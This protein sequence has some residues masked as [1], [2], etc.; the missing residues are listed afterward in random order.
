MVAATEQLEPIWADHLDGYSGAVERS[1]GEQ[2]WLK[3][4]TADFP[5][6]MWKRSCK[7]NSSQL[8]GVDP[9]V[10]GSPVIG[11]ESIKA[12]KEGYIEGGFYAF[13]AIIL[14]SLF[15]LHRIGML[16]WLFFRLV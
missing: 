2:G 11:Y 4:L 12:M 1:F 5:K 14:V 10:T 6:R 3:V 9:D 15:T 7:K 13:L 16:F 8:R